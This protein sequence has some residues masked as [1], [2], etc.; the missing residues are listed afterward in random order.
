M[1]KELTGPKKGIYRRMIRPFLSVAAAL[2]LIIGGYLFYLFYTVSPEKIY[3]ANYLSYELGTLRDANVAP[4]AL[5]DAFRKKDHAGVLVIASSLDTVTSKDNFLA[6]IS[7]MELKNYPLAKTYFKNILKEDNGTGIFRDE[8]EYY[9][10]L[11]C[12]ATR[13]YEQALTL[14]QKIRDE[15]HHPYH[16]S[17]SAKL[18]RE[19]L[20]LSWK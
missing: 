11:T 13:D 6:G 16:Q 8:S 5:E 7:C 15:K 14:L 17:V 20:M 9:L 3:R 2:I 19:V 10:A 18:I 4:S 12:I 1:R